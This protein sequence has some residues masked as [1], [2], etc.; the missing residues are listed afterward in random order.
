MFIATITVLVVPVTTIASQDFD[1]I[2][3]VNTSCGL[4]PA[5]ISELGKD[6]IRQHESLTLQPYFDHNGY[7]VGYGMHRWQ[8]KKVTRNWPRK[9]TRDIVET[10]FDRQL[11]QHVR[12]VRESVC[13]PMTQAMMDGLVSL[14]WNVGRVNKAI[15]R[16]VDA[17]K[18]VRVADFLTTTR[19][20]RVRS[21]LLVE[22]RLREYLMFSGNYELAMQRPAT[23]A[24]LRQH[25]RRTRVVLSD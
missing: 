9:L 1:E 22:R 2:Q 16:K 8:G 19:A 23:I 4:Q 20:G 21:T 17:D 5:M 18:P 12:L 10:E 14:A 15:V 3:W 7:A 6:F 11:A 13:A 25:A 24:M